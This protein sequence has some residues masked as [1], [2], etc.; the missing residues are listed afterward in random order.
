[1]GGCSWTSF[2]TRLDH[3]M[4]G[5]PM[6]GGTGGTAAR[7]TV[8]ALLPARIVPTSILVR[9]CEYGRSDVILAR[10]PAV[11]LR[12]LSSSPPPR[13]VDGLSGSPSVKRLDT[14]GS[15]GA[16]DTGRDAFESGVASR[17]SRLMSDARSELAASRTESAMAEA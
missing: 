1:L 8:R 3:G 10:A 15:V 6:S 4:M 12:G 13:I 17:S 14:V 11:F 9:D 7:P 5:C 16:N 2:G